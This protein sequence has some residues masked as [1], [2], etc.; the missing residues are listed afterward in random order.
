MN[1]GVQQIAFARLQSVVIENA[2]YVANSIA[3]R[4]F[5][6][7]IF[8]E[9]SV[10]IGQMFQRVVDPILILMSMS[11]G[12]KVCKS[13]WTRCT[14][15][16]AS[17]YSSPCAKATGADASDKTNRAVMNPLG[18]RFLF[19]VIVTAPRLVDFAR[20]AS[21]ALFLPWEFY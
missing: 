16:R 1:V 7:L 8:R 4:A 21:V 15:L 10:E 9:F 6:E 12:C 19:I 11:M 17:S 2:L 5:L 13:S 14:K 20:S 18:T 3:Q